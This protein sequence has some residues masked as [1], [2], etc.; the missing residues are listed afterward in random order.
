MKLR[1]LIML[2]ATFFLTLGSCAKKDNDEL[3][4]HHHD[5][6]HDHGPSH[7]HSGHNH[8]SGDTKEEDEEGDVITLSPATAEL[9][10]LA[11]EKA[12]PRPFSA[13]VK[14]GG[15]V[16]ISAEGDAVVSAPTSGIV[17]IASGLNLG[18]EVKAGAVI[19]T[20]KSDGITGGDVNK[21]AKVELDAAKAEFER[22]ESL[23]ADRLVTLSEYNSARAAYERA[24]AAFSA[25]ASAG[26]ASSPISG[27][28]TSFDARTGQYVEAGAPIVSVSASS[29]LIVRVEVPVRSYRAIATARDARVVFPAGG[30]S[31]LLSELDGK[32]LDLNSSAA[33]AGGY[34][35]VTFSVRNDGTLIPGQAVEVYI[36][37]PAVREALAVPKSAL[38]EQQGTFFVFE[39]LDE[40]C[41]RKLPVTVGANDGEYVE[42]TYGLSGGENI[43]SAGVTA[44]R[45]AQTAGAVPE[46]HTHSH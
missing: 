8:D 21:I 13:V 45:L 46:G 28:V 25:P 40:D 14:A 43:V 33:S 3:A 20:I 15:S 26:R 30:G 37:G 31:I 29:R 4:H 44:V 10:R 18:S 19:A 41:Y 1:F 42:I 23:Y 16:E 39:Q 22:V 36:L 7:E 32:R 35:P 27:V 12:M 11:T 6:D 38:S 5:H 34:V 17:T 9:F 24:K 2:A